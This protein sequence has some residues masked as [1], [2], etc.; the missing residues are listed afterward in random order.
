MSRIAVFQFNPTVGDVCGNAQKIVAAAETAKAAGATLLL[1][2]EL[3]LT[4]YS[5]EDLLFK[6]AFWQQVS[7]GL[8]Q[9]E[10][11]DDITVV[12]GH[13]QRQGDEYYNAASVYR[14]GHRLGVYQKMCL[15]NAGVFDEV[16]YFEAGVTPLVFAHEGHQIGVII[17]EDTWATEPALE[18]QEA[19]AELIV[20]LNASPFYVGKLAERQQQVRYRT[21]ESGCAMVYVNT[22]G[23]QDELVFDG[24][25][26]AV[27]ASGAL[28]YQAPAFTERLDYLTLDDQTKALSG[29]VCT[30]LPDSKA[31]WQHQALVLATRDYMHKSGF[32]KACLG[33]SG[34]LDS[35]LVLA[36]AV[37]AIG[38]AHCEVLLMPSQYTADISNTDALTM[39]ETLKVKHHTVAIE[40]MFTA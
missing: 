33:L 5:P 19:G 23:G 21:E 31:A 12:V 3:A 14:D 13:P 16:R 32:K 28:V 11:L 6:P 38:A 30:Q 37:E 15:P 20:S 27:D 35:A 39:A 1:T 24:A 29:D 17:C 34:G 2:P 36:I 10:A 7:A 40:P 4:G 8:D 26:F 25:S 22:V 9:I 18:A